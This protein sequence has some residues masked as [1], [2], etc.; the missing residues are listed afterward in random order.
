M[1][2]TG[3]PQSKGG[4]SALALRAAPDVAL[5]S[6]VV[7]G[8]VG[9]EEPC[10]QG[11]LALW[12][13]SAQPLA[14]PQT[15]LQGMNSGRSEHTQRRWAWQHEESLLPR[16]VNSSHLLKSKPPSLILGEV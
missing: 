15:Q 10:L 13:S 14:D 5:F 16:W 4:N 7:L 2:E 9:R 3:S 12:E 6:L 8:V 11:S 1:V